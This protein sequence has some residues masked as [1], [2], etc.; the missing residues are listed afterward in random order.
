[1]TAFLLC[2]V[3]TTA[4]SQVEVAPDPLMAAIE[5][6]DGAQKAKIFAKEVGKRD[7]RIIP[8]GALGP[9][10]VAIRLTECGREGEEFNML[11]DE[12]GE[13]GP[14][15]SSYKHQLV[16]VSKFINVVY[17]LWRSPQ[18]PNKPADPQDWNEFLGFL[19]DAYNS[20]MMW[21]A[22]YRKQKIGR[23]GPYR[24][25][26][27]RHKWT[28]SVRSLYARL[29]RS[30][31]EHSLKILARGLLDGEHAL[32]RSGKKLGEGLIRNGELSGA[33]A[34]FHKNGKKW[35]ECC[36]VDSVMEGATRQWYSNGKLSLEAT[37]RA[38]VLHGRYV[39]YD[40]NG[41][42]SA[43]GSMVDGQREGE[44]LICK[45][46]EPTPTKVRYKDGKVLSAA[47]S[48]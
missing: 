29:V 18:N 4:T 28:E 9:T 34:F 5:E 44:W 37:V 46:G 27:N 47:T 26:N 30:K 8:H 15:L 11:F 43:S 13:G 32:T 6:L 16:T 7:G 17:L 10:L 42:T 24:P 23:V 39:S 38:G 41:N 14:G 40:Q 1:M 21:H 36:M 31:S 2:V 48:K 33:W 25:F 22:L 45:R 20:G 12:D 3:S 35:M 19:G